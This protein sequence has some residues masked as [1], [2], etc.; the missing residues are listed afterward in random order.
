MGKLI[1]ILGKNYRLIQ[2]QEPTTHGETTFIDSTI[3]INS[4]LQLDS[5]Q[6]TLLHEIIEVLNYNAELKLK[7]N[8][9]SSISSLLYSVIKD[10]DILDNKLFDE[11]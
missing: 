2:T 1:R 11:F 6:E 9:I 4:N 8:Q 7:H 5:K 3:A 10:N